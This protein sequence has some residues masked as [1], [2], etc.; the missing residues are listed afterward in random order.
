MT[1]F[2][3]PAVPLVLDAL[4]SRQPVS[5]GSTFRKALRDVAGAVQEPLELVRESFARSEGDPQDAMARRAA[6]LWPVAAMVSAFRPTREFP[7]KGELNDFQIALESM[8]VYS[9]HLLRDLVQIVYQLGGQVNSRAEDV[10]KGDVFVVGELLRHV[11]AALALKP[12]EVLEA[13][14]HAS[15][16]ERASLPYTASR[17]V[18]RQDEEAMTWAAGHDVFTAGKDGLV[19]RRYGAIWLGEGHLCGACPRLQYADSA[20]LRASSYTLASTKAAWQRQAPTPAMAGEADV[21]SSVY[22]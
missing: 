17:V 5:I 13:V 11:D 8:A 2:T 3:A 14:L 21:I 22:R 9:M 1:T 4:L 16:L 20:V 19:W 6:L 7:V 10:G 18:L 15:W 12:V